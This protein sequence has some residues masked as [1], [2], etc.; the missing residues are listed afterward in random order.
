MHSKIYIGD[1]REVLPSLMDEFGGKVALLVTSPPY[2]VGRGYE[3]YIESW[4][5]YWKMLEDVFDLTDELIEPYGKIAINFADKY[6]N[7]KEFGRALEICYATHYSRLMG[8]HDLYARVIWDKVKVSI[9]GAKHINN[10]RMRFI[11]QMRVSPNWEYIFVWR[12]RGSGKLPKKNIDMTR[13][14]WKEWVNGIWRFS[15][16]HKNTTTGGTKL[17]IFPTELPRRLIKM[18]TQP[19]DIV[20]DPFVGTGTTVAVARNLGRIGIGIEKNPNMLDILKANLQ[21]DM[22]VKDSVEF[23]EVK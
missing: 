2:Y 7:Y 9:D 5:D 17:A 14:E 15:S 12:K 19:G 16:V 6:G 10:D 11:G 3:D 4:I 13:D 21:P 23:I 8:M 18:Y 22:F 20:I 1:S